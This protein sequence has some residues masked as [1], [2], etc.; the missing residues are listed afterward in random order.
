MKTVMGFGSITRFIDNA[1]GVVAPFGELSVY[2]QTFV[3]STGKYRS[4][5]SPGYFLTTFKAQDSQTGESFIISTPQSD[6]ILGVVRGCVAYTDTHSL[7]Y[8][9]DNFKISI[10]ETY[11]ND[12]QE[13]NFGPLVYWGGIGLPQ[14]VEFFS[15]KQNMNVK[16]W[17]SDT[18]FRDQYTDSSITV[19]PVLDNPNDFFLR[20]ED[21]VQKVEE[22]T[23]PKML[24]RMQAAKQDS[25]DTVIRILEFNL[26]NRYDKNIKHK[27]MFG[28]LIYGLEGDNEDILKDTL[29]DYLEKNSDY[30]EADWENIF[31]EIYQRT[32]FLIVP[33]F[34]QLATKNLTTLA[35]LYSQVI[36][37]GNVTAFTENFLSFYGSMGYVR[38]NSYTIN[39]AWRYLSATITNGLK[40][41]PNKKDWKKLYPD[42][43]PCG[44]G[45]DMGRM[46]VET[47]EWTYFINEVLRQAEIVTPYTQL[48]AGMR[49]TYR[50][51]KL[52]VTSSHKNVNYLVAAKWNSE[53]N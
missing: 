9:L 26:Y 49:K 1:D 25:P 34:D 52:F 41:D 7:P 5:T 15:S 50:G 21:V 30:S 38:N 8:D 53:F 12:V 51:T 24:E 2:S 14:F 32:E 35:S 13:V 11:P 10:V 16:V 43:I 39:F 23:V 45:S 44:I 46:A 22:V 28:F 40:N 4:E 19:V 18:A 29:A 17:L 31:P 20:Y 27:V 36:P 3:K 37:I 47:Q 48:P 33:R 6:L 42:Y